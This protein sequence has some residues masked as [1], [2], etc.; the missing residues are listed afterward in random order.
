MRA[1]VRSLASSGL[2]IPCCC[3]CGVSQQLQLQFDPLAWE[4]PYAIGAAL[5]RKKKKNLEN[6][7]ARKDEFASM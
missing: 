5:K 3:G 6:Y 4:L 7:Y 2:R 1:R